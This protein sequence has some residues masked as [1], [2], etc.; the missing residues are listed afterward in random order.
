MFE[1]EKTDAVRNLIAITKS[2]SGISGPELAFYGRFIDDATSYGHIRFKNF[3]YGFSGID[4]CIN[5]NYFFC[6]LSL[7]AK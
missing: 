2:D 3:C 4:Y 7:V 1:L 5:K 6:V